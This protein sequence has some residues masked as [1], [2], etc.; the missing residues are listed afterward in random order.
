[1]KHTTWHEMASHELLQN[2]MNHHEPPHVSTKTFS[3][4]SHGFTSKPHEVGLT[5]RDNQNEG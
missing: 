3:V 2:I 1:M 5:F 4:N